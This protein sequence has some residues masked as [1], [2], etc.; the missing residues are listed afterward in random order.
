MFIALV[1]SFPLAVKVTDFNV[2]NFVS[3][4]KVKDLEE[5]KQRLVEQVSDIP[6]PIEV[7]VLFRGIIMWNNSALLFCSGLRSRETISSEREWVHG[8][9]GT[10]AD[11]TWSKARVWNKSFKN[12]KGKL[13]LRTFIC[14]LI[15]S[16]LLSPDKNC[17]IEWK[18]LF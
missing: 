7:P 1:V 9:Q 17:W 3:R 6:S 16:F 11:E 14:C 8:L 18:G 13:L 15:I 10:T 5:Q 2:S 12:G 4:M